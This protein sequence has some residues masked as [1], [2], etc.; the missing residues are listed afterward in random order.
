MKIDVFS[1]EKR[2]VDTFNNPRFLPF[3]SSLT[4]NQF[5]FVTVN[6]HVFFQNQCFVLIKIDD[7]FDKNKKWI[8]LI[9]LDFQQKRS[10]FNEQKLI[11]LLGAF[12]QKKGYIQD[13]KNDEYLQW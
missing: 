1:G 3:F 2:K 11:H 7:F 5:T 6:T 8:R 13:V 12:T 4:Q 10:G 9:T